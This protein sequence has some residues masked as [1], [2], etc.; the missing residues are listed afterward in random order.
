[1]P[2]LPLLAVAFGLLWSAAQ[3]AGRPARTI[4]HLGLALLAAAL[5]A[6]MLAGFVSATGITLASW[7]RTLGVAAMHDA[8][9]AAWVLLASGLG[10]VV[11]S[12]RDRNDR[13]VGRLL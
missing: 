11:S 5:A 8:E 10:S 12:A 2:Y 4:M 6:R 9:L 13:V 7:E 1:V 3:E